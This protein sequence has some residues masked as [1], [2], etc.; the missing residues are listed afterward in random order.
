MA[1]DLKTLLSQQAADHRPALIVATSGGGTRAALFTAS[2]LQGLAKLGVTQ[3]IVLLS[4]V[5]GGGVASAYFYAHQTDLQ[6]PYATSWQAWRNFEYHMT[7]PF[8]GDVLEGATEWRVVSRMALGV[9][10]KESLERQLFTGEEDAVRWPLRRNA[11]EQDAQRLRLQPSGKPE[12]QHL[13][14]FAAV[15]CGAL[16][17]T[18]VDAQRA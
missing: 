7:D 10:L 4:G 6:R 11:V 16:A 8:I 2:A 14:G 13:F 9:L 5:S 1:A 3:D 17:L 12:R 15:Q 18:G